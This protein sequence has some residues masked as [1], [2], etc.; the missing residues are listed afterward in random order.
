[1]LKIRTQH[2]RNTVKNLERNDDKKNDKRR[3]KPQEKRQKTGVFPSNLS[4]LGNGGSTFEC[5]VYFLPREVIVYEIK[6]SGFSRCMDHFATSFSK[7]TGN[8]TDTQTTQTGKMT[9]KQKKT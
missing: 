4:V 8:V 1:M 5:N 2:D 9:M 3:M 6:N 7:T